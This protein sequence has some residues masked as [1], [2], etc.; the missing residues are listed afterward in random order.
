M[1]FGD[2]DFALFHLLGDGAGESVEEQ[3]F[4][5]ELVGELFGVDDLVD[6]QGE[7]PQI[8]RFGEEI[9]GPSRS[10]HQTFHLIGERGDN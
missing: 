9:A 5:R 1:V 8:E 4:G 2:V 7:F 6:A 10:T 3:V